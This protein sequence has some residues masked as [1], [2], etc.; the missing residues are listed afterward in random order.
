MTLVCHAVQH[1]HQ[2]AI[3]HRD[4]KP[5]NV[6]VTL[7][8]GE[9]VPKVIDF[10]VAKALAQPLT[11]DSIYTRVGQLVGTPMYMSPE[12]AELS[13]LD[14]DT[15]SDVYSLGVLLYEVLTDMPPFDR[16]SFQ[17]AGLDAMLDLIRNTDPPRPS[18]RVSTA[19][20][21]DRT[22]AT[23]PRQLD[24]RRMAASLRGDL[25]WIVM[26]TLEKQRER[27]YRSAR[28]LGQDLENY[29]ADKPVTAGPPSSLYRFRKTVRRH[30]LAIATAA[31][32]LLSMFAGTGV[33]VWYSLKANKARAKQAIGTG[34]AGAT[35]SVGAESA[36]PRKPNAQLPRRKAKAGG[37][38]ATVRTTFHFGQASRFRIG[39]RC[40]YT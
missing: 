7:H 2:K 32:V 16:E 25:D 8:D 26:K 27:R 33:S 28:E 39:R 20:M 3:I 13:D 34:C 5:S 6:L 35:C 11:N 36:Q 21:R 4:I 40:G 18:I 17:Q 22:L 12:Q 31:A 9:S 1:A 29:L 23:D 19:R 37:C 10:G 30:R 24:Q 15:R 14:V 38:A